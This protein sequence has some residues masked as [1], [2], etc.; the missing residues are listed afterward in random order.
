MSMV[1]GFKLLAKLLRDA[2]NPGP[3]RDERWRSNAGGRQE[4]DR[5]TAQPRDRD[6]GRSQDTAAQQSRL[7]VVRVN[8]E[9]TRVRHRPRAVRQ[10]DIENERH[11]GSDHSHGHCHR[12]KSTR[13]EHQPRQGEPALQNPPLM[14]NTQRRSRQ[15]SEA[16]D[17]LPVRT[18]LA[19]QSHRAADIHFRSNDAAA[20]DHHTTMVREYGLECDICDQLSLSTTG[21]IER[22]SSFMVVGL[23][24]PFC[25]I[26]GLKHPV[27]GNGEKELRIG[28]IVS[29][30]DYNEMKSVIDE[31]GEQRGE[32]GVRRAGVRFVEDGRS[33]ARDGKVEAVRARI[34][35]AE[36][37]KALQGDRDEDEETAGDSVM[38]VANAEASDPLLLMTSARTGH[39]S[40]HHSH[41]QPSNEQTAP[42]VKSV[43]TQGSAKPENT[44]R[45]SQASTLGMHG[46]HQTAEIAEH[47]AIEQVAESILAETSED[48]GGQEGR[49]AQKRKDG[50]PRGAGRS[51]L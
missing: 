18:R 5:D 23:D 30:A 8:G 46:T 22:A 28:Q 25:W 48:V 31:V 19:V 16:T 20:L 35:E 47:T 34:V 27:I 11:R 39:N 6:R 21:Y 40:Y 51:G 41:I 38:Q 1:S 12:T 45:I 49:A 15:R 26:C 36:L 17:L 37:R 32:D 42:L 14:P 4:Q 2:A 43:S 7:G 9:L 13:Q 3:R 29:W 50:K 10:S 44:G 33:R 24:D